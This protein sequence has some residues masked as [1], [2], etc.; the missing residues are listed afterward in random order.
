ML[1]VAVALSSFDS[2]VLT[3]CSY[4]FVDNGANGPETKTM[5]VSSSSPGG[6]AG[7]KSAT[8]CLVQLRFNSV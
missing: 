5:P 6:G 4:G 2:S 7:V 1:P 8:G 3:L